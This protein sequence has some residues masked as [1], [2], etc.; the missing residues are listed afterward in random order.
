MPLTDTK[1]LTSPN[2]TLKT[3]PAVLHELA[4][5]VWNIENLLRIGLF[6]IAL[7]SI[8]QVADVCS[9]ALRRYLENNE[10]ELLI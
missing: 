6:I 8:V 3:T 4:E 5:K 9:Y 1:F 10:E 7:T 2:I